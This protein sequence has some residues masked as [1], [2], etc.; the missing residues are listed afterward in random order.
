MARIRQELSFLASLSLV[1]PVLPPA[2]ALVA[3]T[4]SFPALAPAA[5]LARA[6]RMPWVMW[7]QDIVTEGAVTTGQLAEGR[8]MRQARQFERASYACADRIVVISEAFRENL[9]S[10]GV[11][12]EKIELI[13]NPITR[14][15]AEPND[16]DAIRGRPPQILAMGNIGHTQGLDRIVDAF[17]GS[18][19]LA[20]LGASLVIAGGGVAAREVR[21]R[22]TDAS[23]SMPGI[24][25]GDDLAPLLRTHRR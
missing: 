20:R 10:K 4:P 24:L 25:Y 7:L 9:V 22:V 16:L 15:A 11:P 5:A 19:E 17:Q 18:T 12:A 21:A 1:A 13:Y 23:V 8:L 3:V 14:P 6:R 2:D